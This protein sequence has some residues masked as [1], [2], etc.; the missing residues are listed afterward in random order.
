MSVSLLLDDLQLLVRRRIP[1][2]RL[3][4]EAVELGFRQWERPFVL[5]RVFRRDQ[6]EGIGQDARLAV[7]GDLMLGHR[8]KKCRL[9]LRHRAVDLVD[10]HDVRED[11][12]GAKLEVTLAL[13]VDREARDVR[14]LQI[15]RALD[16]RRRRT[17]DR[18]SD[19]TGEHRLRRPRHILEEHMTPA[20]ER[21][22]N[23]SD[24]V[25]LAVDDRFDVLE[26]AVRQRG[27]ALKAIRSL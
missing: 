12:A 19:R 14:G 6:Q 4:E 24:L 21:G 23:E 9:R 10:E 5:D 1:E 13:V 26:E 3:Q 16:P 18:L 8:F 27:G 15:R 2:R 17:L 7:D 22:E 11:R 25:A 20:Q